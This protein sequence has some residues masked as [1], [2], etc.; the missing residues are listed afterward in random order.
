M[1]LRQS[2]L[3]EHASTDDV[4]A[5]L[6]ELAALAVLESR[7]EHFF[8]FSQQPGEAPFSFECEIVAGGIHSSRAGDYFAFLGAFVEALTGA[9]GRVAVEDL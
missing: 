3:F 2:F 1:G 5:F 6:G 9:F 8:L 4:C 7:D